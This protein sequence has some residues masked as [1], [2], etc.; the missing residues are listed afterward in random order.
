MRRTLLLL[1]LLCLLPALAA[2]QVEPGQTLTG[3]VVEVTDGDTYDIRRSIGGEVTVRLFGV[4]A[5]E[6]SQSYGRAATRAARRIIG[7]SNV[8][9]SVEDVGRYGR[10]IGRVRVGRGDLVT[11][12]S[13]RHCTN[14]DSLPQF[15]G[16]ARVMLEVV[17]FDY[18]PYDEVIEE[19]KGE[20]EG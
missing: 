4:D 3:R 9:I 6:S 13:I 16:E 15:A 11:R 10:A 7:G 14:I 8:R 20:E 19:A 5:P 1:S 12:D 17:E 2:A 18:G